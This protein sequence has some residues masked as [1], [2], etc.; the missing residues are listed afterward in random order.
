[1]SAS[2]AFWRF[3][4]IAIVPSGPHTRNG[5]VRRPYG[6]DRNP[7]SHRSGIPTV[8]SE[9]RWVMKSLAVPS[10]MCSCQ[11]RVVHE[12]PQSK[13]S[14]SDPA[15]TKTLGP[16]RSARGLG[17]PVPSRTTLKSAARS[18]GACGGCCANAGEPSTIMRQSV[19]MCR[20]IDLLLQRRIVVCNSVLVLSDRRNR[21]HVL[22]FAHGDGQT[23]T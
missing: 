16:N 11:R 4:I 18:G 10:G 2:Y 7:V 22:H 19:E 1:M 14:R 12:R 5:P 17:D 21:D 20:L 23:H 15:S 6:F 8:W 3:A 9:C 13:T